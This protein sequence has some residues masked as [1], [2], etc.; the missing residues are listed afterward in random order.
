VQ[1]LFF[2]K[3]RYKCSIVLYC[4]NLYVNCRMYSVMQRACPTQ[5]ICNTF[6]QR[7][8]SFRKGGLN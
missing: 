5:N 8:Q 2:V 4:N 7:I 3:A 6:H 1:D